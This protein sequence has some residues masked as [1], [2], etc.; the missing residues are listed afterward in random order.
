MRN[1]IEQNKDEAAAEKQQIRFD[2]APKA[3]TQ[4]ELIK[5]ISR[6]V[7]VHQRHL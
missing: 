6:S 2:E 4:L 5:I 1:I 7:P 3:T